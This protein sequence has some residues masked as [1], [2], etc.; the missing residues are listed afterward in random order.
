[1]LHF[2]WEMLK[3]AAVTL[4]GQGIPLLLIMLLVLLVGPG[5]TLAAVLFTG[6]DR[7]R[8]R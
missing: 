4:S 5:F 6:R 7:T 2:I 3:M 1:M 8:H